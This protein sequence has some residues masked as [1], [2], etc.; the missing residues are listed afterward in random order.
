[1]ERLIIS[2]G[3][4]AL[5]FVAFAAA[6]IASGKF[7][8][9][10]KGKPLP[11]NLKGHVLAMELVRS[12]AEVRDVVG[13]TGSDNRYLMRTVVRIDFLFIG[14]Y[15]L[16]FL[17][18]SVLLATR[19]FRGAFALAVLAGLCGVAATVFDVVENLKILNVLA[20]PI[21]GTTDSMALGIRRAAL[22]KWGLSFAAIA[23]LSTAFF[24][25]G[26]WFNILL[27][28]LFV[29]ASA[30]GFVGLHYHSAISIAVLS[31]AIGASLI[32]CVFTLHPKA[33]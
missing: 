28:L 13:D 3:I 18:L 20:L 12:T 24:S 5:L 8:I 11:N 14:A 33:Y 7:E 10:N 22:Y 2:I 4:S 23:I 6:M 1:M 16:L 32:G 31:L 9:I 26:G 29:L 25:R 15:M 27:A 30:V 17:L 21:D 19:G